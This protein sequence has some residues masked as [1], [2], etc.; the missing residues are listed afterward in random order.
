[1]ED[2]LHAFL[3]FD[4]CLTVATTVEMFS[5]SRMFDVGKTVFKDIVVCKAFK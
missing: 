1:V 5:N 3:R 4:Q 2:V